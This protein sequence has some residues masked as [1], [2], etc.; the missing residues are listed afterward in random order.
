MYRNLTV[1]MGLMK[2]NHNSGLSYDYF[3]V[4]FQ[5]P[6]CDNGFYVL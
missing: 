1:V 5:V 3:S 4:N 2:I 6:N